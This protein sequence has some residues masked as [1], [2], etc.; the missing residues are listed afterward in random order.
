MDCARFR[1]EIV[2]TVEEATAV[3][4]EPG[5][6]A[7]VGRRALVT[8]GSRGIG[9]AVVERLTAEGAS[10]VFTYYASAEQAAKLES[11]VAANGGTAI[12]ICADSG[13]AAQ[14]A[15]AVDVTVSRLGGLDILVNNASVGLLGDVESF[16]MVEFDRM[17]AV[18]VR[19]MFAA[20]QRAIPHLNDS[21]RIITIGSVNADRV[22]MSG[23]SVYTM[24]KAAVAG[25]SRG[26]ARELGPRGITVNV[27]QPGPTA[28]VMNPDTGESADAARSFMA[29]GHYGHPRDT[30]SIVS[31]LARPESGSVTGSMWNVDGGYTA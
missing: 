2:M 6:G 25:L 10:V 4:N 8:G 16:P 29:V 19:A 12:G 15:G 21:G 18:N 23:L 24:T 9:A 17:V 22:P 31:Y 20:I 28:T 7:L 5:Y 1:K 27:V 3:L 26:L 30:A 14:V 11:A 13:D